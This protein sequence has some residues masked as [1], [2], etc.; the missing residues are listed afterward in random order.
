MSA[1]FIIKT[2]P[3]HKIRTNDFCQYLGKYLFL[4]PLQVLSLTYHLK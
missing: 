3:N 1:F 2:I 4:A